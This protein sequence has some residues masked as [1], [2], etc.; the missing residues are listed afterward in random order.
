M[1]LFPEEPNWDD[2]HMQDP[3]TSAAE[4]RD[5]NGKV[6]SPGRAEVYKED[7]GAFFFPSD[8]ATL[9]TVKSR[10]VD[11]VLT[12]SN[13]KLNVR[14]ISNCPGET[15]HEFPFHIRLSAL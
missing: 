13:E 3:I 7:N 9:H 5:A 15:A 11:L 8:A 10:T 4:L 14:E 6:V 12:P 1:P 2:L